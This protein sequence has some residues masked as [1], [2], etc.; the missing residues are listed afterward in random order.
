MVTKFAFATCAR[1]I[2]KPFFDLFTDQWLLVDEVVSQ[3]AASLHR[4]VEA[5]DLAPRDIVAEKHADLLTQA[6]TTGL[7][8]QLVRQQILNFKNS[9]ISDDERRKRR[10]LYLN[11]RPG[12][13]NKDSLQPNNIGQNDSILV[14]AF[15]RNTFKDKELPLVVNLHNTHDDITVFEHLAELGFDPGESNRALASEVDKVMDRGNLVEALDQ[16]ESSFASWKKDPARFKRLRDYIHVLWPKTNFYPTT[17]VKKDSIEIMDKLGLYN[18]LELA[19]QDMLIRSLGIL[20]KLGIEPD[21]IIPQIPYD[22]NSAQ[23]QTRDEFHWQLRE[24]PA[25]MEHLLKGKVKF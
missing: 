14:Q 22:S 13:F 2:G 12:T 23:S 18:P 19:H 9:N 25:R 1:A 16:W 3:Y 6:D 20:A 4:C 5:A 24:F 11:A 17:D 15:G 7:P 10:R 8:N 21:L